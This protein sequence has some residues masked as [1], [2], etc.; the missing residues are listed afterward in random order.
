MA[1]HQTREGHRGERSG[2]WDSGRT[3]SGGC[4]RR[5][6]V[7]S[8]PHRSEGPSRFPPWPGFTTGGQVPRPAH[9]PP[10][11]CEHTNTTRR[12]VLRSTGPEKASVG[13]M[14]L[15]AQQ[16]A[17]DGGVPLAMEANKKS[18]DISK[19][20]RH[21]GVIDCATLYLCRQGSRWAVVLE[22]PRIRGAFRL[23]HSGR[24]AYD[25][26]FELLSQ[27]RLACPTAAVISTDGAVEGADYEWR[28][29]SVASRRMPAT[30]DWRCTNSSPPNPRRTEG[31]SHSAAASVTATGAAAPRSRVGPVRSEFVLTAR[32]ARSTGN[33]G[34]ILQHVTVCS[35][36]RLECVGSSQRVVD[37]VRQFTIYMDRGT[38]VGKTSTVAPGR[39]TMRTRCGRR[40]QICCKNNG[41]TGPKS[42]VRTRRPEHRS[43]ASAC[44]DRARRHGE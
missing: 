26:R 10:P 34:T 9:P 32:Q 13:K 27:A 25:A 8:R 31:A 18:K 4:D 14:G 12:A 38:G 21:G 1:F 22:S 40:A 29:S 15:S 16:G 11:S 7:R 43:G 33:P 35:S 17:Q 2:S 3:S 28:L 5:A 24:D 36:P 20:P 42:R 37:H 6:H 23:R 30:S 44:W 41:T 19:A 39:T